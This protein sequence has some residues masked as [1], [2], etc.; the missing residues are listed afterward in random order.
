MLIQFIIIFGCLALGE[1]IVWL[2]DI[3]FPSCIIGMILLT[4]FL[5][6]KLIKYEWVNKI[7]N[8][9]LENLAFFFVPPSVALMKYFDIIKA[10]WLPIILATVI[11][12]I[13]VLVTSGWTHQILRKHFNNKKEKKNGTSK[14]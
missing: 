14:K 2:T 6:I 7:S 13:I 3:Q 5:K 1:L 11:S 8:F 9:L 4:F 10:E 12:T